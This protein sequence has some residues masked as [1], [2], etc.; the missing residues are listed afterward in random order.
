VAHRECCE[1]RAASKEERIGTDHDRANSQ[2]G[3]A[4]K[5]RIERAFGAG[6]QDM[7]LHSEDSGRRLSISRQRFGDRIGW[8]DEQC[9]AG[10]SGNQLVHQTLWATKFAARAGRRSYCPSAQRYSMPTSRCSTKPRSLRPWRNALTISPNWSGDTELKKPITGI[11]RCCDCAA[12][13]RATPA[14]ASKPRNHRRRMV[15]PPVGTRHRSGTNRP[16]PIGS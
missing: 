16:L 14:P 3:Q 11:D 2:L 7:E 12:R 9:N 10:R 8:I 6:T 15:A 13:G 1:L 4:C 5:S